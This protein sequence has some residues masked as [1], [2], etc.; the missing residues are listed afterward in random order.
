MSELARRAMDQIA[1]L[2]AAEIILSAYDK[3][4]QA[5]N[6]SLALI[7]ESQNERAYQA[8]HEINEGMKHIGHAYS[9]MLTAITEEELG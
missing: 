4:L 7:N 5:M 8:F 3:A 9:T 6:A 2:T 1:A